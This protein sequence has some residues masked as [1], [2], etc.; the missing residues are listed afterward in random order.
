MRPAKPFFSGRPW[1]RGW[2][3][4][5]P[6]PG[7]AEEDEDE[8]LTNRFMSTVLWKQEQAHLGL[9]QA[10]GGDARLDVSYSLLLPRHHT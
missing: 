6:W 5:W 1:P 10:G 9:R 3:W 2:G 8:R 4:S 7:P